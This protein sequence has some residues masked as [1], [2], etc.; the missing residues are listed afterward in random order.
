MT[1]KRSRGFAIVALALPFLLFGVIEGAT[2][3]LWTDGAMPLFIPSAAG[4]GAWL[5]PNP[6]V[7]ARWFPGEAS[8]PAPN[9]E[10]FRAQKSPNGFRVFVLGESSAQGFPY[11][12]TGS[13][14]RLLDAALTDALPGR[15]V[16]VITLGIAATNSYAMLDVLPE[17]IAQH[18]DAVLYYGGHNEY[19]G[20]LGAGASIRL[21]ASPALTRFFVR[22][23]H[24]RSVRA[25]N[26]FVAQ[27]RARGAAGAIDPAAASFMESVTSGKEVA[28]DSP[29]YRV[30]VEQFEQNLE[31]IVQSMVQAGAPLYVASTPSNV[32]DQPPFASAGNSAAREAY[33]AAQGALQAGDSVQAR[34]AFVRARD[35]DVVRFRAP[36]VFDSVVRRVVQRAAAGVTYVPMVEA[37]AAQSVVGVPGRD[38]FLEHVHPNRDGVQLLARTFLQAMIET[39]PP[40]TTFEAARVRPMV[41]YERRVAVTPFDE[42]IAAHRVAALGA[43]WPFV[44][45]DS[46][47]DYRGRYIPT[48][49]AD[50]LAFLVAG[51]ARPWEFAKL[52]L[53]RRLEAGGNAAQAIQ[54]YLGLAGDQFIFAEP[55]T[56]A[57]AALFRAR[58]F[59]EADSQFVQAMAIAPTA[60]LA[61]A[62][63]RIA[64][65]RQD[66]PA[67]LAMLDIAQKLDRSRA[68]VLY[69]LSL[70]QSLTGNLAGAQQTARE[71]QR[72][73]PQFPALPQL[74][75]V[76]G[77]PR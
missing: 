13:F 55:H 25:L 7:A 27:R 1:S 51:G 28:S 32:R 43:R 38:L 20:A 75:S 68:D 26:R 41:E 76:L 69:Q 44:P 33:R 59:A 24:L 40:G 8:P 34:T 23:Q 74:L 31:R 63:A 4:N 16:E 52:E 71:L 18:P 12:R 50:S 39:P 9:P 3:L 56:L 54:E 62:R 37:F 65:D 60:D 45:L 73:H 11:P 57:G 15:D 42:R 67:A 2:R 35:L 70:A 58:R 29:E 72:Q 14:A 46:Q 19:V 77:L 66:W 22:L 53:A 10:F 5:M 17:V 6:V 49:F 64:G 48:G 36:S 21:S 61:V 30:G 47:G